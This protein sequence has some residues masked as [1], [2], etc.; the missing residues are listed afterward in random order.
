MKKIVVLV[1][2][3]AISSVGN[4]NISAFAYA[5]VQPAAPRPTAQEKSKR[6]NFQKYMEKEFSQLLTGLPS[7]E[8]PKLTNDQK[9]EAQ[10]LCDKFQLQQKT[11]MQTVIGAGGVNSKEEV[12]DTPNEIL[13]INSKEWNRSCV[14]LRE[15]LLPM[16][17]GVSDYSNKALHVINPVHGSGYLLVAA[18]SL[19]TKAIAFRL[20]LVQI[21]VQINQSVFNIFSGNPDLK[22]TIS[23]VRNYLVQ[24]FDYA[25]TML[26]INFR[27]KHLLALQSW[28]T[29]DL[30]KLLVEAGKSFNN[31]QSQDALYDV[32]KKD[33]DE[34]FKWT[35]VGPWK[36]KYYTWQ[37]MRCGTFVGKNQC[38]VTIGLIST[39]AETLLNKI[40][41]DINKV[42]AMINQPEG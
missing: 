10:T 36:L 42:I 2:V 23:T 1:G 17:Q 18:Q 32:L 24:N 15:H 14:S 26:A 21:L 30:K 41:D 3:L 27:K 31:L 28:I 4:I 39:G 25:H 37:K 34:Y 22:P 13:E 6:C 16:Y 8:G 19:Q 38:D 20:K 33:I 9:K 12:P 35:L 11:Q 40:I 29:N 5:E 7:S